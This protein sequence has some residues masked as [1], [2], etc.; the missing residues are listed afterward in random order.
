M[1][2]TGQGVTTYIQQMEA[3]ADLGRQQVPGW[4]EKYKMLKHLRWIRNQIAH[5]E[6]V[7][8]LYED[9][10]MELQ[11]FHQHLLH[12]KDPLAMVR[13]PKKPSRPRKQQENEKMPA[14]VMVLVTMIILGGILF[15]LKML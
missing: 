15:F 11:H 1:F 9:D 2:G 7:K 8:E 4:Q 12:R 6:A 10:L 3:V 14:G 13:G 5:D